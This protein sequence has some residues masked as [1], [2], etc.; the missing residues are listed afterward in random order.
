MEK[1]IKTNLRPVQILVLGF[2]VIILLGA[3]L[4]MLP[5]ATQGSEPVH[6]VDAFFTA[7]SAVCVTGLVVVDTGTYWSTFGQ[8]VILILIQIGGLGFMTMATSVSILLGKKIGLRNRLIMQEALNQFSIAGVIRLTRYVV[9]TTLGIE[10]IGAFLLSLRFIPQFGV[11]K[12]IYYAIFHSVSA[13]CNAGFDV[14]GGGVSL[15]NYVTDPLVNLVIVMLVVIGGLGFAVLADIVKTRHYRKYSL[16]SKLAITMT[17]ILVGFAFIF[18]FASEF[19]NPATIGNMSVGNKILASLFH[20]VT[21]R[22]AGFNTLNMAGLKTSTVFFTILLMF[23]GGSSGSTAGGIKTT[24]MGL[25]VLKVIS[26]VRGDDDVEFSHRRVA[27]DTIN[28]ALAIFFIALSLVM[29]VILVLTLTETSLSFEQIAFESVSAFA[30]VGLSL[31]ITP[32]LSLAGKLIISAAM[33]FGRL[34]PLTIV[35]A[36]SN[37]NDNYKKLIR[38]P[39]GKI[40]VG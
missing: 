18:M 23:I 4:L 6:F 12:G 5:V 25:I 27:K 29:I 36:I 11:L 10:G 22:T 20:A 16:H 9:L 34:G 32:M 21:P 19:N 13:F 30:T 24:T 38:Y 3:F 39:E 8:V 15:M 17:L 35:L 31:G 2:A 7:T 1:I 28:R 37:H 14:M 40:M 26:V 33:F